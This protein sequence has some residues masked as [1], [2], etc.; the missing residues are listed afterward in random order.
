M[1]S[2]HTLRFTLALALL[3][4]SLTTAWTPAPQTDEIP[5]TGQV[6]NATADSTV[7]AELPV[8]LHIFSGMEETG[9][10]TTTL[11]ADNTFHFDG[12]T[13]EDGDIFVARV[14]YEDVTY[15]S[16]FVTFESGQQEIDLPVTIYESTD[17]P[18][19][20]QIAQGHLFIEGIGNDTRMGDLI[21]VGEYYLL[22]NT[23]DRTYLGVEDAE[24]GQ[25][26]TLNF[27]LPDGA[28]GLRFDDP[29]PEER[30]LERENGFADTAPIPPGNATTEVLF[31]YQLLYRE[32]MQ[33]E[34]T[35]EA[36]VASVVILLS[37]EGLAL[38]GA[39]IIPGGTMDT[40]M[41][42]AQS[43]TAGPL[44]A[45][46]TLAFSLVVQSQSSQSLMPAVPSG[47]PQTRNPARESSVGL[48]ALAI[49][50]AIVY[51]MW[52][53]PS[54]TPLPAR[55]RPLVENIAALDADF[56]A[57]QVKEGA[58]RKKRRSLKRQV[59][60]L[61]GEEEQQSADA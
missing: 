57:G 10:Y 15:A 39:G 37:A 36:P 48:V 5:V 54:R 16:E 49:A 38:E 3:T 51:W 46:E 55:A 33:V 25:Q 61:L 60:A 23:G 19:A 53:T 11:S 45:G 30:F 59:R 26:S 28:E 56:E 29:S 22:G 20:I 9:T 14:V 52:Q 7:P 8:A 2:T 4:L 17:D 18:A 13:P 1:K 40:Q 32:G 44:A 50:V 34:R 35:F 31:S 12:L 21:N 27:G 47:A 6:V 42:A 24:T 41:G 43:Y 58:Y